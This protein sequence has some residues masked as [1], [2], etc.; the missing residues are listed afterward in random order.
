MEN[1]ESEQLGTTNSG[2]SSGERSV[3]EA[4]RDSVDREPGTKLDGG[5][6]TRKTTEPANQQNDPYRSAQHIIIH[7]LSHL[8]KFKYSNFR[9][10]G[11]LPKL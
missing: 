11:P 5:L 8:Y 7:M 1:F 4:I 2:S 10:L 9:Q 3:D 6:P